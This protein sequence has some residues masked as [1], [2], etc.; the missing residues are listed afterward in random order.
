MQVGDSL[1]RGLPGQ[2]KW[3]SSVLGHPPV[4]FAGGWW[5][6]LVPLSSPC[7]AMTTDFPK[8]WLGNDASYLHSPP[9]TYWPSLFSPP[10]ADGRGVEFKWRLHLS[11]KSAEM[12]D[13]RR[14]E[15]DIIGLW[16][17][18]K[19]LP[20]PPMQGR[21]LL[22]GY[23]PCWRWRE[24]PRHTQSTTQSLL[25]I[26]GLQ[27]KSS[28]LYLFYMIF[29]HYWYQW[30]IS[31]I[32]FPKAWPEHVQPQRAQGGMEWSCH[33]GLKNIGVLLSS[34]SLSCCA[35]GKEDVRSTF[36]LSH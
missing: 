2:A 17:S 9:A 1:G 18:S 33:P 5:E 16:K 3:D 35:G 22:G 8:L 30:K 20:G 14:S 19:R 34:S 15:V 11:E 10:P 7:W 21:S 28:F 26:L 24:A 6:Q 12:S 29:L 31:C 25:E 27:N 4:D 36:K 13:G 23:N 32:F